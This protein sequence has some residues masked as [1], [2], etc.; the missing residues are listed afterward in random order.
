MMPAPA[1]DQWNSSALI[2]RGEHCPLELVRTTLTSITKVLDASGLIHLAFDDEAII[3]NLSLA[4][5]FSEVISFN[6]NA[7]LTRADLLSMNP[8][9]PEFI[10]HI[11][12]NLNGNV[13]ALE[14]EVVRDLVKGVVELKSRKYGLRST[15]QK[16]LVGNLRHGFYLDNM[17]KTG[18]RPG[19]GDICSIIL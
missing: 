2:L 15:D 12:K 5:G 17:G 18:Q 1:S 7:L 11:R 9:L 10:T 19:L 8:D 14:A 4:T 3:V 16:N 6:L 13:V